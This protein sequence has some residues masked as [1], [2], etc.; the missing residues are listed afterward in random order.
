MRRDTPPCWQSGVAGSGTDGRGRHARSPRDSDAAAAAT[1]ACLHTSADGV[2]V[3]PVDRPI[4]QG[5][6]M[7]PALG[8]WEHPAARLGHGG[9]FH[10]AWRCLSMFAADPLPPPAAPASR[11][12]RGCTGQLGWRGAAAAGGGQTDEP[13]GGGRGGDGPALQGPAADDVRPAGQWRSWPPKICVAAPPRPPL[14]ALSPP[15]L[16]RI[17]GRRRWALSPAPSHSRP[18]SRP[19]GP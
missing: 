3:A 15:P 2:L 1:P 6:V 12:S 9:S 5:R 11:R 7:A 16:P 14:S 13:H 4:G 8:S 19:L 17:D 18:R 10:A